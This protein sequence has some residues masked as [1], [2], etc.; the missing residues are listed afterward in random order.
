MVLA[1]GGEPAPK[2]QMKDLFFNVYITAAVVFLG[3]LLVLMLLF[4]AAAGLAARHRISRGGS[5]ESDF[6]RR[7][8][9]AAALM[10]VFIALPVSLR[11]IPVRQEFMQ[12][13]RNISHTAVAFAAAF[14]LY[15]L[16]DV[17]IADIIQKVGRKNELGETIKP[18][19]RSIAGILIA[20]S[21][22]IYVLGLWGIQVAPLLAGLGIA[23]LALALALQPLLGNLF[24]GLAMVLDETFKVGDVIKLGSGEMGT[25]YRV[26]LRSTKVRTFDNEMFMIPNTK[27]ADSVLQNFFQPDK[28]IRV[29]VDFGVEYGTDPEYVKKLVIEEVNKISFIDRTQEIR[30]LFTE[31]GD[32]SLKFK[33]LFWVDDI[34]KRWPAHQEA[35]SRIYRRLY[36]EKIGIPFPQRTVWLREEGKTAP[37]SPRDEKFKT[38]RG[39]YFPKFGYEYTDE[40]SKTQEKKKEGGKR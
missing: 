9:G 29:N 24:N 1:H 34:V 22:A 5:E 4:R 3:L 20:V 16:I 10:S 37:V 33:S 25:V 6:F 11:G 19:L 23:G 38:V 39:K 35:L 30:V 36:E 40:E 14:M 17:Y 26:G 12:L 27:L 28:S 15:A 31:M 8:F 18:I 21:A 13:I 32:S 7:F 2:R